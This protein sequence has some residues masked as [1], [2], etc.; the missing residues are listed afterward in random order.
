MCPGPRLLPA[1]IDK[2]PQETPWSSPQSAED[3]GW[4]QER[5]HRAC[6]SQVTGALATGH[7]GAGAGG[8]MG[9]GQGR[10]EGRPGEMQA[11]TW[12]AVGR[13]SF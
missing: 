9:S 3:T 7:A 13:G 10:L 4:W 5:T 12:E 8:Q 11:W 1:L 2:G 6:Q